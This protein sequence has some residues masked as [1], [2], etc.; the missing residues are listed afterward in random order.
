MRRT[1][2]AIRMSL[3]FI[4]NTF[5]LLSLVAMAIMR[6][7]SS[8]LRPCICVAIA[9][10]CASGYPGAA[11]VYPARPL[12]KTSP[13][14]SEF[15]APL[16]CASDIFIPD[17]ADMD[18]ICS[19]VMFFIMLFI[20]LRISGFFICVTGGGELRRREAHQAAMARIYPGL[21]EPSVVT[22]KLP[23][24]KWYQ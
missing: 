3:F 15:V 7:R 11:L 1:N 22:K 24:Q 23:P 5:A 10:A 17:A 2:T 12:L 13:R 19:G 8:S 9:S 20:I 14:S 18:F 4:T 16:T 21:A 6:S